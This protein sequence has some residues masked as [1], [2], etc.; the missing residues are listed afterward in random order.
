MNVRKLIL[1]IVF[2]YSVLI[3]SQKAVFAQQKDLG[4]TPETRAYLLKIGLYLQTGSGLPGT[5]EPGVIFN[6]KNRP[7]TDIFEEVFGLTFKIDSTSG[8]VN[9]IVCDQP[10]CYTEN[11]IAVGDAM[12]D[13]LRAY[14]T[15]LR[16]IKYNKEAGGILLQYEGVSFITGTRGIVS[17]IKIVPL[18][19]RK[20]K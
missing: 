7:V 17:K 9:Y 5:L 8:R 4:V 6:E 3:P 12:Q 19:S 1:I 13:V 14:G 20:Y 11:N 18:I 10:S 15:P 2:L 16:E